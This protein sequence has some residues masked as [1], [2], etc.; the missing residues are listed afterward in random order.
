[1]NIRADLNQTAHL[2]SQDFEWQPSPLPGVERVLLD[3]VGDEVAVATSLVRY[4]P[5][6]R[7]DAHA[8]ELG[9]EFLVLD[10]VFSDEHGDYPTGSY[11]RN[12][13][14]TSHTPHSDPGCV[15]F[16]KLRQFADDD[17]TPVSSAIPLTADGTSEHELFRYGDEEISYVH[18][19][20]GERF[21]FSA[22]Y[23]V[24]ELLLISGELDWQQEVTHHL[25]PWSWIRMAPGD[26]LRVTATTPCVLLSK[27]RPI[28][29][30]AD[31]PA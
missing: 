2:S 5:N 18:V 8:H 7:F 20:A 11:L 12:P 4:A 26:P 15:I 31:R 1:M 17:L 19:A 30:P 29:R 13:P 28:Y 23:Y 3:R 24:R 14:G 27:S 10:G 25:T 9:E 21:A 22:S 6:A 16:V